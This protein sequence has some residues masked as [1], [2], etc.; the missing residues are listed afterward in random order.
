M[1]AIDII[2]LFLLVLGAY[3][4]YKT[5]LLLQLLGIVAFFL[6]IIGGFQLMYWGVDWL[7]Q[8]LEG[9][10]SILPIISFVTIFIVILV[11]INLI[12]KAL[13]SILDMTLLGGFDDI[14]GAITG[15]LKWALVISMIIWVVETYAN[16]PLINYSENAV[17]FPVIASLAPIVFDTLSLMIPFFQ[18]LAE[19]ESDYDQALLL[20]KENTIMMRY[21]SGIVV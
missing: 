13:K 20:L 8:Y 17:V 18:N 9:Y 6:A 11:V 14:T 15:L 1:E 2:I 3:R 5:G 16:T 7:G 10:E 19:P 12:G 4:G 21:F